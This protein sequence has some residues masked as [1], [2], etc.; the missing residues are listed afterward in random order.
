MLAG[1][2]H[3]AASGH[4]QGG[5]DDAVAEEGSGSRE[6]PDT[7]HGRV[8]QQPHAACGHRRR[9][10]QLRTTSAASSTRHGRQSIGLIETKYSHFGDVLPSQSLGLVLKN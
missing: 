1:G 4:A 10:R 3:L 2:E 8:H 9:P 7:M 5:R 6:Q